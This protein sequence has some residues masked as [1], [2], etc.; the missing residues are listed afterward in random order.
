MYRSHGKSRL[1][2]LASQPRLAVVLASAIVGLAVAPLLAQS[3]A[4][5]GSWPS[6]H[7]DLGATQ[8]ADLDQINAS[9]FE[10]L[11]VAWR[12]DSPDNK[13]AEEDRKYR[14][15]GYKSTPLMVDGVL[16][17][18]T[19]LGFVVALEAATGEQ[20]WSFDTK[21]REAGRPTNLGFNSRGVAYW[22]DGKQKRIFQASGDAH[23]WAIDATTG[24][25]VG[26]FG[27][28][29]RVNL[30]ATLRR[31]GN[32]RNI[33]NMSPPLVVKDV[34][35]VG[36]S[37]FDGP[38]R[39]RMPPGDVRAYDVNTGEL[40]WTFHNPPEE[41]EFG[42]ETWEDESWRYTGNA[43]VWTI[44]SADPELGLVYLPFG[45]PTNDWYGGHR[46]GDNLF[47]ES[48][49]CVKAET[50]ERVWHYQLVHHGLW[51]YDI[52]AAPTLFDTTIDGQAVK[53]VAVVTKQGFTYVFDRVTGEPVWPIEERPVPA[54]DVPGEKAA[55]TQPFPTKPPPFEYQG[56]E[57]DV[58]IDFTPELKKEAMEFLKDY[59]TGPIY[60]PPVVATDELHGTVQLPG[61][62]GG[63]NWSGAALD[64]ETAMLYIP[65]TTSPIVVALQKP[66]GARSD[67][68]YIRGMGHGAGSLELPSGLP[69]TKPPYGR[70]TAV[71]LK[72][73]ENAWMVPN[74]EGIRQK[75]IEAGVPDPGPVGSRSG[76]GP[77]LTKSLLM[78]AQGGRVSRIST[79]D[80]SA[81]LRAHDKATG[82]VLGEVE[83][84]GFPSG[85]PMTYMQGGRQFIAL[86]VSGADGQGLVALTVPASATPTSGP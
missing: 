84:P 21:S 1:S 57:E 77:L 45:T 28:G 39:Q 3:G 6:Y 37:I 26:G 2:F 24:E 69:L 10:Q 7:G 74:G 8:Y 58:L 13:I 67:F 41:G 52:P 18:N 68:D 49:V 33:T 54:S 30:A 53:G 9:N 80:T 40:R 38:S 25:P 86:A 46:K 12:W 78:I 5:S 29:G 81:V 22:S 73:G 4:T 75:L 11:E 63:A 51:D 14:S 79:S 59:R 42:V 44:M 34:V 20:L 43:N 16:Y 15:F 64:P 27:D 36:S 60:T 32:P 61:W 56:M 85:T 65:S 23:L 47:A 76:T 72:S 55:P 31:D 71:D 62:G 70:I 17:V 35:I 83:L 19:S 50:G 48:I 66:D 82:K